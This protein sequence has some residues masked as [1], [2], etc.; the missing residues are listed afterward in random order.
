VEHWTLH[1]NV[2]LRNFTDEEL[3]RTLLPLVLAR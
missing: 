3:D 2:R 1:K